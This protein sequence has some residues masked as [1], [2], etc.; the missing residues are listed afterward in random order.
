MTAESIVSNSAGLIALERI[1][2]LDLLPQVYP[3]VWIPQAVKDEIGFTTDWMQIKLV[4]NQAL[5]RT[6]R[7]QIGAGESAA[8]ALALEMEE[9][10]IL[11]DDKKARRIAE[12]LNLKVTGT[13]GLLLKAKRQG[14]IPEIRPILEALED[15]DFR[16]SKQL[17]NRALELANE[18]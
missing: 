17:R 2:H 5:V 14:V 8:I 11:L 15:V 16:I 12:H 3:T 7:T 9:V 18:S 13:V 6:L 1:E 10:P 4:K